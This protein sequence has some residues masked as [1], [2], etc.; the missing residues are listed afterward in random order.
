MDL[1]WNKRLTG[2]NGNLIVYAQLLK[3]TIILGP[4]SEPRF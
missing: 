4:Q 3:C 2:S 1:K